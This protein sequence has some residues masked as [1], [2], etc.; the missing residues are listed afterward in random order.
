MLHQR[1]MYSLK[2]ILVIVSVFTTILVRADCSHIIQLTDAAID[3]HQLDRLHPLLQ[4][5]HQQADC[6]HHY[7]RDV[8][9]AMAQIAAQQ[10]FA[11]IQKEQLSAAAARLKLAPR[12]T[13]ETQYVAGEIA[14]VRRQWPE[15]MKLYRQ[16]LVLIE[17]NHPQAPTIQKLRQ[18]VAEAQLLAGEVD[19]TARSSGAVPWPVPV[20]FETDYPKPGHLDNPGMT[21]T[22]RRNAK[23]LADYVKQQK[24]DRIALIGH[25]DER[26]SDAH[27]FRLSQRRACAL[28]DFLHNQGILTKI[29]A[30]G[31]GE[32]EPIRLSD[33]GRYE[34]E[35]IWALNRRVALLTQ[36]NEDDIKSKRVDCTALRTSS[37]R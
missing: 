35:E 15:A 12:T 11:M 17:K 9:R 33:P 1:S 23:R 2:F 7:L 20:Q 14:S 32:S 27:N 36:W 13:W 5:L 21:D 24:F 18:Y 26:G 16:A 31:K 28:K 3:Q 6:P 29:I 19:F 22:G 30:V 10:A 8:E 37:R 34:E 4:Q 25:T